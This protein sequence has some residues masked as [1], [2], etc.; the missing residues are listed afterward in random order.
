MLD[1]ACSIGAATDE[2]TS[3][4]GASRCPKTAGTKLCTDD[5]ASIIKPQAII[6]DANAILLVAIWK[7]ARTR[8]ALD[9]LWTARDVTSKPTVKARVA[10]RKHECNTEKSRSSTV[11]LSRIAIFLVKQ[12]R[13]KNQTPIL[14]NTS[15]YTLVDNSGTFEECSGDLW[16]ANILPILCQF[17]LPHKWET[18]WISNAEATSSKFLDNL[19]SWQQTPTVFFF[20]AVRSASF[21]WFSS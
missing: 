12:K 9:K 20:R 2:L 16:N 21:G 10:K 15:V 19:N 14:D 3:R 8:A 18:S 6:L 13:T 4:L 7:A 11:S 1:V 17:C 5:K